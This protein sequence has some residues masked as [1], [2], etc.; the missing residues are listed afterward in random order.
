MLGDKGV[1][2]LNNRCCLRLQVVSRIQCSHTS[3]PFASH[4][5]AHSLVT[6]NGIGQRHT[7]LSFKFVLYKNYVDIM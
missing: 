2:T 7:T 4:C 6:L 5:Y 1:T 3:A